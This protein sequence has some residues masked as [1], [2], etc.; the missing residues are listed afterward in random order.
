MST[1]FY[2]LLVRARLGA[3]RRVQGS[4][5]QQTRRV[6]GFHCVNDGSRLAYDGYDAFLCHDGP[7]RVLSCF[8]VLWAMPVLAQ[9]PADASPQADTETS[10]RELFAQG[11]E[12]FQDGRYREALTSFQGVHELTGRVEF[13][14][15]IG[16]AHQRLGNVDEALHHYER[17]LIASPEVSNRV[18]VEARIGDLRALGAEEPESTTSPAAPTSPG[19]ERERNPIVMGLGIGGAI[20]GA[21]GAALFGIGAARTGSLNDSQGREWS[22]VEDEQA[23][24]RT[25]QFT[26]I[27]IAAV[28]LVAATVALVW[29]LTSKKNETGELA[30]HF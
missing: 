21:G 14:F 18:D 2:A 10:A 25:L 6:L 9:D 24:A 19:A 20:L 16:L 23:G 30:W 7:M 12:A 27:G 28:G 15:N 1:V 26:G 3:V 4:A 13:L 8:L 5:G 17:Y 22:V 29:A 11:T